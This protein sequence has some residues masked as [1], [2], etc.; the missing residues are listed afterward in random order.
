MLGRLLGFKVLY[1][2]PL[3]EFLQKAIHYKVNALVQKLGLSHEGSRNTIN[4]EKHDYHRIVTHYTFENSKQH[5]FRMVNYV[6]LYGFLRNLSLTFVLLS[7][8]FGIQLIIETYIQNEFSYIKV[9]VM[10]SLMFISYIS[11]M[12]FMKFYRRYTLEGLMLLIVDE[13]IGKKESAKVEEQVIV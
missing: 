5:Q 11:F 3:D 6:A 2:K 4:L 1:Q 7:W 9:I 10:L 13:S 8:Y 12:A